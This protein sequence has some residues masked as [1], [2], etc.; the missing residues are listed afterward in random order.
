[1]NEDHYIEN[2]HLK[3]IIDEFPEYDFVPTSVMGGPKEKTPK[4]GK[5]PIRIG[6]VLILAGGVLLGLMVNYYNK[7]H[8][9]LAE[10]MMS[11]GIPVFSVGIFL[12]IL[13]YVFRKKGHPI[14]T[15]A[16]YVSK[17]M[18]FGRRKGLIIFVKNRKFGVLKLGFNEIYV[19]PE[20]DKLSWRN[21][22]ILIAKKDSTEFLIDIY[23]NVLS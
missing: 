20:Y 4:Y 6:L 17:N 2:L 16:D 15:V 11:V 19:S 14:K 5:I 8:G 22:N 1:M 12:V 3:S 18:K 7:H 9:G 10:T 21:K 13:G 23:G